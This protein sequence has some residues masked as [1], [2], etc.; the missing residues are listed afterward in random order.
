MKSV[1]T[2]FRSFTVYQHSIDFEDGPMIS[3]LDLA[4][5][6]LDKADRYPALKAFDPTG[7]QWA[8]MHLVPVYDNEDYPEFFPTLDGIGRLF[9]YQFNERILPSKVRDEYFR[10]AIASIEEREGRKVGKKE[11]AELKGEAEN[12]LLPKAFIKRSKVFGLITPTKLLIFTG[13]AKRADD[14]LMAFNN[15][16]IEVGH[17]TKTLRHPSLKEAIGGMTSLALCAD[18]YFEATNSALLRIESEDK[19]TIRVKDKAI[20][21]ADIQNL[22]KQGYRV[23]ELGLHST[24]HKAAFTLNK[25]MTVKRLALS[26]ETIDEHFGE[27]DQDFH[28]AAW[29][30]C[31]TALDVWADIEASFEDDEL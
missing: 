24:N 30:V 21:S 6:N 8:T 18:D 2:F 5:I 28:S 1:G 29:L 26:G 12:N 22:L 20:Y 14:V 19:P 25:V 31:R 11:F 23:H 10:K 27:S 3:S 16:L 13:I 7:Q 9:C 4:F 17:D 15:F